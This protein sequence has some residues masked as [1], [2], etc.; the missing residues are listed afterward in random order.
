MV[1]LPSERADAERR[2]AQFD[3]EAMHFRLGQQDRDL[4]RPL[5]IRCTREVNSLGTAMR[6]LKMG[7]SSTGSHFG[8]PSR[9]AS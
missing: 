8:M 4:V 6:T 1:E 3:D 9:M 2:R 5:T 7:S